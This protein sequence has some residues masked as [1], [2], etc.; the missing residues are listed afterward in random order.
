MRATIEPRYFEETSWTGYTESVKKWHP[1]WRVERDNE[2]VEKT[3]QALRA[4]GKE[5][6][7]GYYLGGTDGSMT[8]AIHGIPTIIYGGTEFESCHLPKEW[9]TV[10][11]M[12]DTFSGYISILC[13][14]YGIERRAF[15]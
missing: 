13:E 2:F 10:E 8:C 15:E 3:F 14:I 1:A 11:A 12:T 4:V 9:A 6:E 5:P 7:E